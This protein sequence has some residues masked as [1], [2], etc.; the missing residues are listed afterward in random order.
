MLNDF[1]ILLQQSQSFAVVIVGVLGL[2]VGSFLNV[3]IHRTPLIMRQEWRLESAEFWQ[4]E[5]DLAD[6]HKLA[7]KNAVQNDG[8]LTLSFPPSRCP[9]CNHKITWAENI[10]VASWLWLKGKCKG[11]AAPISFRYPLV[12]VSTALLSILA[13]VVLGVNAQ[14]LLALPFVWLLIALTGIDFDTQLLP[15]RLVYPLGMLGLA[16]NTQSVFVSPTAA[17]W[18]ALLGFLSLWSVAT[19][20]ALLTKKQGMGH[21][22][23]KLLAALGAWLG[24]GMLP[25]IILLSSFIGAIVGVL[26]MRVQGSSKPFAFGPYI[27]MAGIVALLFGND[28]M[29]WYLGQFPAPQ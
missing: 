23:F 10:P 17:M 19:L 15:D 18:G 3:V 4:H 20:Y 2:C 27:A 1:M 24:A 13:I 8:R 12:E 14:G 25:M 9:T 21:G 28:I 29:A 11:C 16:I 22:D 7:L 6:P 26:L 5:S